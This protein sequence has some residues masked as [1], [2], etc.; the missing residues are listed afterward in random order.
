MKTNSRFLLPLISAAVLLVAVRGM[1]HDAA[2]LSREVQEAIAAFKQADSTMSERFATA[3]G[4]VVFPK[5]A[6]GGAGIGA[7][8]GTGEVYEGGRLIGHATLT[9]VTIGLQLGGQ[10]FSEVIFFES[11]KALERFKQSKTEMSAQ[12]GAVAAAEG[13][14]KDASYTDGVL[15]FTKA[16]SGLM[17]E[18]SVGGQKFRFKPLAGTP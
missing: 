5:V 8:R 13:A 7:A 2:E 15:I 6:K 4:Y 18:A 16:R 14:S 11:S 12:I 9:Q 17:A 3:A 10:S 1:A